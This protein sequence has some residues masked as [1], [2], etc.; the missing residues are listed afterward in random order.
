MADITKPLDRNLF[1]YK[2]VDQD[3]IGKLSEDIIKINDSDNKIIKEA[4]IYGFT[5][6]PEPIKIYIDS[7]GGYV[8]QILGLI[9]IINK[10]EIPIHTIATGA[11]MSSGFMLLISGHR[12]FVYELATPLYHQVSSGCWDKIKDMEEK[13]EEIQR[14][15]KILEDLTLKRTKINY[16]KLKDV[17]DRKF[18]WY[19]TAQEALSLGVVDEII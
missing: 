11:A 14:L 8:Y 1:F 6:K 4:Q 19:M 17:Y 2:D 15:Q 16:E 9:S 3:S 12:R 18:D 7:Y 13:L 5:Y 10:S